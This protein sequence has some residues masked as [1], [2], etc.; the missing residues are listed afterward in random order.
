MAI[1][2]YL[3]VDIYIFWGKQAVVIADREI[4]I[5]SHVGYLKVVHAVNLKMFFFLQMDESKSI[6]LHLSR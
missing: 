3:N 6:Y 2:R 5:S 1:K 4:A